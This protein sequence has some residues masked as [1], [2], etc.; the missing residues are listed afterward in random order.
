[1]ERT[2]W[3]GFLYRSRLR[4][5]QKKAKEKRN[6]TVNDKRK[7]NFF[8]SVGSPKSRVQEGVKRKRK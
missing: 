4:R 6:V 8:T 2:R 7:K 1:V 3:G 5:G